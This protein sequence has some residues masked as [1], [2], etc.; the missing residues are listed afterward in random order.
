MNLTDPFDLEIAA[1]SFAAL[2]SK[3]CLTVLRIFV[4]TGLVK[5]SIGKLGK[6]SGVT[7]STLADHMKIL[8]RTELVAQ[9]RQ[10]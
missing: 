3:Q 6:R 7:S 5:L 2:G 8:S 10:G 4:R 9:S 1:S